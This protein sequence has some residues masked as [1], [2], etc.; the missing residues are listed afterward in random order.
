M[1]N[2]LAESGSSLAEQVQPTKH[3]VQKDW[4]TI[5]TDGNTRASKPRHPDVSVASRHWGRD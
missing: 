5:E 2:N 3:E 4:W 1:Q